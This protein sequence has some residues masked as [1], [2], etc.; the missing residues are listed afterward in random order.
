MVSANDPCSKTNR[1]FGGQA[2]RQSGG[3]G[4]DED[5]VEY[6]FPFDVVLLDRL[7]DQL[8]FVDRVLDEPK[9]SELT[10][11]VDPLPIRLEVRA[12]SGNLDA[13]RRALAG[14]LAGAGG[15]DF[16]AGPWPHTGID[17][18]HGRLAGHDLQ[19]ALFAG[20]DARAATDAQVLGDDGKRVS[21]PVFIRVSSNFSRELEL[22]QH[23]RDAALVAERGVRSGR[24]TTLRAGPC[25]RGAHRRPSRCPRGALRLAHRGEME[26]NR[27]GREKCEHNEDSKPDECGG[28]NGGAPFSQRQEIFAGRRGN[29]GHGDGRGELALCLHR[30]SDR[31]TRPV[32][33]RKGIRLG[34]DS[35][36][37]GSLGSPTRS[38]RLG[39]LSWSRGLEIRSSQEKRR[40]ATSWES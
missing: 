34:L 13:P 5:Q 31:R 25:A 6:S 12:D 27:D 24:M 17:V 15:A 8:A 16:R 38:K 21:P 4:T 30:G 19:H 18:D 10:D 20:V 28:K 1:L 40:T 7:D 14:Q 9:T 26:M 37:S 39:S 3:A 11:R 2:A 23:H 33:L 32:V 35:I 22:P 29:G 36:F